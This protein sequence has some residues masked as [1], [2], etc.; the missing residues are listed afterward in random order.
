[1]TWKI[2]SYPKN[3]R[4]FKALIAAKYNGVEVEYPQDFKMGT[5][6]KTA[7]FLAM[8]PFGKV[9]TLK[10]DDGAVWESNSIVRYIARSG[11]R[12]I[13]GKNDL[14]AS[15]IDA[16]MDWTITSLEPAFMQWLGPILGYGQYNKKVEQEAKEKVKANLQVLNSY[17]ENNTFLVGDR[18]S[19]ADIV[20][21][22]TLDLGYKMVF[23]PTYRA[24]FRAV[25]RW[26]LTLVNQ[27]N[28]SA[29]LGP[30]VLC[31]KAAEP[32]KEEPKKEEKPKKEEPK[33]EQPKKE[34][35]AHEEEEAPEFEEPKKKNPLDNLPKSTFNLEEF[36]RVYSN[37]DTRSVALPYLWQNFDAEGYCI[38]FANYKYSSELSKQIF[39]TSNL[40]RGFYQRLETL[41]KYAFGSTMI[42]GS[43]DNQD[44]T[45]CWIFRGTEIPADMKDCDDCELYEWRRADPKSDADKELVNDYFAW[46]KDIK[47]KKFLDGKVF[48]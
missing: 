31:D 32:K 15:Q 25:N 39:M 22:C 43:E 3:P 47:G 33:K 45:G 40:I 14:E 34:E 2:F 41:H 13:Y 29:V 17:L 28:F 48:K 9:P 16:W 1:M 11:K 24:P 5:E 38:Y 8:N 19:A 36:K 7:E 26:Y 27:P 4:V 37:N 46:D 42:I 10:A 21:A 18:I 35:S 30:V 6:N 23:E 12:V 20:L 44:I